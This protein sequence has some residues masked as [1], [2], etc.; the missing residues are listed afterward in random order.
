MSNWLQLQD[1][2]RTAADLE[3]QVE[4]QLAARR[5]QTDYQPL[6]FAGIATAVAQTPSSNSPLQTQLARLRQLSLTA[7]VPM[8]SPSAASR[9]PLLGP[10][11]SRFRLALHQ[12]VCFYVNNL[13]D[14]LN[15]A[16][17]ERLQLL[18]EI[19]RLAEAQQR[20]IEQLSQQLAGQST[21]E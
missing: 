11:W 2:Q 12:L 14:Q 6:P 16:E 3:A 17:A 20:Q 18:D 7:V 1:S 19:S 15:A 9:L 5:Q 4:A 13:A 10:V 21:D 8:L